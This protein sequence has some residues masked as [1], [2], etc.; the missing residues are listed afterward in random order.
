MLV[1]KLTAVLNARSGRERAEALRIQ[2]QMVLQAQD[3]VGEQAAHQAE[4]Q[5]GPGILPPV[6]LLVGA[7]AHE[8]VGE[9]LQRTKHGVE[10]GAAI[11]VEHLHEIKAHGFRDRREGDD[12]E[13]ELQPAG[14]LHRRFVKIFQ[15]EPSR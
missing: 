11:G 10:P 15:D 1:V 7:H 9:P 12:V 8:P 5:H 2:R 13:G 4:Q 14:N 6:L 3:G